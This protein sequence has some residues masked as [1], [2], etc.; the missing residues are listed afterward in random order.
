MEGMRDGSY[1]AV[2]PWKLTCFIR[3]R[4]TFCLM[5]LSCSM[6]HRQ[7]SIS[8][9]YTDKVHIKV[10]I[11]NVRNWIAARTALLERRYGLDIEEKSA[12]R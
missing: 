8:E 4:S 1:K 5:L 10:W 12:L 9:A 7:M 2:A 11:K 3:G 6:F